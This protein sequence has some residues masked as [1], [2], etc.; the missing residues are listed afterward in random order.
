MRKKVLLFHGIPEKPNEKIHE[1][2]LNV[3]TTLMKIPDIT[4]QHIKVCHR[5]GSSQGKTRPTLVR[6]FSMEQRHM[7]WDS[8]T[9]LKGSGI[10]LSEFLTKARHRVFT[11]ARKHFGIKNCWTLE[12]KIVILTPDHHRMKIECKS[13][14]DL[15]MTKFPSISTVEMDKPRSTEPSPVSKNVTTKLPTKPLKTRR[16]V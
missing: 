12:G 11:S 4:P 13:E 6:F 5:L 9:S 10:T 14:L 16:R 15:L 3:I 2:V 8:K 7:V 1:A